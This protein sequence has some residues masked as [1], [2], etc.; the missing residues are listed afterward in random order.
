MSLDVYLYAEQDVLE[1][2][3]IY[4]REDGQLKQINEEEFEHRFP[5]REPVKTEACT[6]HCV[7][8]A[9]ITHNLG[10]MAERA[11]LYMPLWRPE[12]VNINTAKELAPLLKAGLTLLRAMPG[13]YSKFNPENGWGSYSGLVR[14]VE[15]YLEACCAH[16]E[17]SIHTWR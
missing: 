4:V 6:S 5:G 1:F 9:N 10:Q 3:A 11:G 12:E 13:Y 17:A 7:F 2:P 15:R 14:F 16:P 8:S